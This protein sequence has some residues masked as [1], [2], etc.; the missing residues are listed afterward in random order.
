MT[1][2]FKF[3]DTRE[4]VPKSDSYSMEQFMK[5]PVWHDICSEL[6]VWLTEVRDYLEG[7]SDEE[8]TE[9]MTANLRGS[10]KALRHVLELPEILSENMR[11]DQKRDEIE[12][13]KEKDNARD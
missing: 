10:A 11:L 7:G 12:K 6:N 4:Y 8:V 9:I 13:E 3:G 1:E 5:G 2:K